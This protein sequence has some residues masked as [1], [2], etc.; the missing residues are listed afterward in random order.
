MTNNQALVGVPLDNLP[1]QNRSSSLKYGGKRILAVMAALAV[2]V[3]VAVSGASH[4][5]KV[6]N[7]Q[8]SS[9]ADSDLASFEGLGASTTMT[10][11]PVVT[12]AGTRTT[13]APTRAPTKTVRCLDTSYEAFENLIFNYSVSQS[14]NKVAIGV[15]NNL[16]AFYTVKNYSWNF[17]FEGSS[18]PFY[19]DSLD[20]WYENFPDQVAAYVRRQYVMSNLRWD[21]KTMRGSY[22]AYCFDTG[23]LA[24][25]VLVQVK[26][27]CDP[28][29]NGRLATK[30]S[31]IF[32]YEISK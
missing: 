6:P 25:Q 7:G 3:F 15:L 5:R 8:A 32:Y 31:D 12:S 20:F 26:A 16:K 22:W 24:Q 19:F 11:A 21:E 23:K 13:P 30:H 9:V 2:V 17:Y 10:P 1:L 14:K 29:R 28:D 27:V 4:L 18:Q